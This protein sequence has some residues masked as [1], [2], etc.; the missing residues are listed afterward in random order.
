M[1][2]ISVSVRYGY[3]VTSG[4]LIAA[5]LIFAVGCGGG[6]DE[7]TPSLPVGPATVQPAG[8]VSPIATATGVPATPMPTETPAPTA[9]AAATAT[10]M[11][12][13]SPTPER[14]DTPTPIVVETPTPAPGAED[15]D[16]AP[17]RVNAE[18]P[19]ECLAN[20]T[21][22]DPKVIVSCSNAAMS[23]LSSVKADVEFNLAAMFGG[24]ALSGAAPPSISMQI[25]RVLPN[26]FKAV[27]RG[28]DGENSEVIVTGGEFYATD[29]ASG[30]WVKVVQAED[31]IAGLLMSLN[32]IEQQSE[33]L[34]DPSIVWNDTELSEDGSAYV[35]SYE[36]SP[37]QMG[38]QAPTIEV[39]LV[40]NTGSLL[41]QSASISISADDGSSNR[42]AEIKY[43]EHNEPFVIAAP[44]SYVEVDPSDEISGGNTGMLEEDAAPEVVMLSK[45]SDG[46]VEVTFSEP[47]AI[48]GE[49]RL[50]VLEPSTGGWELPYIGG[51]GTDTLTF[52]ADV[53]D[54]PPLIPG[55]SVIAGFTFRSFESDIVGEDGQAADTYFEEWVYP[56]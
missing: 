53:P 34:D 52:R 51:E 37:E 55:E 47:V 25:I 24:A 33:N 54:S 44:E 35:V 15:S 31:Q 20:G 22:S 9:E 16:S 41:H 38:A 5:A 1:N 45:N 46:N 50:Y 18:L 13:P 48:E 10:A 32:M 6:S 27:M 17:E 19:P 28:P 36:V 7:N 42:L 56:E 21:L 39:R 26:D 23:S 8:A 12:M 49:I 43:S 4:A 30:Q 14:Q 40:V 2:L 29:G 3:R 11:P